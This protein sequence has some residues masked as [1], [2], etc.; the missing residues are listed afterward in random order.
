MTTNCPKCGEPCQE[1]QVS[2]TAK[3]KG[4]VELRY[5]HGP[6]HDVEVTKVEAARL[7]AEWSG[8]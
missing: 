7:C 2:D 4:H 5:I 6:I 8:T 1:L 3:Q